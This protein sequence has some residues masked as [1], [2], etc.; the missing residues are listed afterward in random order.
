VRRRFVGLL[1][2]IPIIVACAS[3][4]ATESQQ[5]AD[6]AQLIYL[7]RACF[8]LL[9]RG[10][11]ILIDPGV[12]SAREL[13]ID[14]TGFVGEVDLVL[15]THADPDHVNRLET[16]PGIDQALII[17]TESVARRVPTLA[18]ETGD[19][20]LLG[21]VT[22]RKVGVPHG[23]RHRVDHTG[24]EIRLD[25][26]VVLHLG[27]G[28]RL[29]QEPPLET[30]VMIVTIGGLEATVGNALA[31]VERI[32]PAVVIPMHWSVFQSCRRRAFRFQRRVRQCCP[33]T[34]CIVPD[35]YR[36][37]VVQGGRAF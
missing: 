11:S 3:G 17:G 21:W 5:P 31:L 25:D 28:V 19:E 15:V 22:V 20:Y 36:P 26:M 27:D 35:L 7:G 14:R 6:S 37:I 18:V 29:L 32:R 4:V 23:L 10:H 24:Y 30:D 2:L 9:Q 16:L 8:L 13:P 34:L 12:L 33:K 1:A